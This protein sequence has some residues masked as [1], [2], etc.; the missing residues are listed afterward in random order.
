MKVFLNK[1]LL[2]LIF[3]CFVYY[4]TILWKILDFVPFFQIE[5]FY[6]LRNKIR[7]FIKTN[8]FKGML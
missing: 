8:V 4:I 2:I 3:I 1:Y 7:V 6:N 5:H